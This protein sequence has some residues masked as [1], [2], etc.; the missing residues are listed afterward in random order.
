MTTVSTK[1]VFCQIIYTFVICM[2]SSEM[3]KFA[4][5]I[6]LQFDKYWR[7]KSCFVPFS[8]NPELQSLLLLFPGVLASTLLQ[9]TCN[10]IAKISLTRQQAIHDI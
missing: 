8:T 4:Q 2:S 3:N 10:T 9:K 1:N 5:P 7:L 6:T